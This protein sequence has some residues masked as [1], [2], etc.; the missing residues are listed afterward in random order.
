MIYLFYI[1]LKKYFQN[2]LPTPKKK[3]NRFLKPS[4]LFSSLCSIW[5]NILPF[6]RNRNAALCTLLSPATRKS[7]ATVK[8][9]RCTSS[10]RSLYCHISIKS[11]SP[12]ERRSTKATSASYLIKMATKAR[13]VSPRTRLGIRNK[14][15]ALHPGPQT[16]PPLA[17]SA[18]WVGT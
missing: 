11:I 9:S 6:R 7:T 17:F 15:F 10:M 5:W 8:N 3:S 13:F 14:S 16:V 2:I 1:Y 18:T 4:G 12:A